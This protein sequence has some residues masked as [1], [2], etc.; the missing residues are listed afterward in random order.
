M[1]VSCGCGSYLLYCGDVGS[2]VWSGVMKK[3]DYFL[4]ALFIV[5]IVGMVLEKV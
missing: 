1:L 5:V 4:I 2:Y 3:I